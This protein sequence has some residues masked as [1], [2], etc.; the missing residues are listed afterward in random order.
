[1]QRSRLSFGALQTPKPALQSLPSA[2]LALHVAHWCSG[3][4]AGAAARHGELALERLPAVVRDGSSAYVAQQAAVA[5]MRLLGLLRYAEG[6]GDD[7]RSG[8]DDTLR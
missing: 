8:A 5:H 2:S 7:R 6:G 1:M 4:A 3:R